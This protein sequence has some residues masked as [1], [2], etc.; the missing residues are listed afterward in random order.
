MWKLSLIAAVSA[1]VALLAVALTAASI[2]PRIMSLGRAGVR[3][4]D[5]YSTVA[6]VRTIRQTGVTVNNVP[7]MRMV[8]RI[9]DRTETRDMT[10]EQLIDFG[11]MP[12]AG[13]RV[14]V[15]VDRT[16]A[17]RVAYRGLVS[18]TCIDC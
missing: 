18:E 15:T 8:L 6:E 14:R 3:I 4:D 7:L 2:L 16:D 1:V 9:H 12:R 5:G 10:I 17:S 11:N 13:E